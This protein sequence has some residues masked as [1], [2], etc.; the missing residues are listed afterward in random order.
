MNRP[1]ALKILRKHI[2]DNYKTHSAFAEAMGI[3]NA[4]LSKCINGDKPM[5]NSILKAVNIT[6]VDSHDYM[7]V[8]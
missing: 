4:L 1:S 5:P 3:S 7:R 8:K 2:D 6:R